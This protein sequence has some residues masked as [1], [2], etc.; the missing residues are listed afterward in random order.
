MWD[1]FWKLSCWCTYELLGSRN[2]PQGTSGFEGTM[3]IRSRTLV[4][5]Y[6][7]YMLAPHQKVALNVLKTGHAVPLAGETWEK[8]RQKVGLEARPPNAS[9]NPDAIEEIVKIA[10]ASGFDKLVEELRSS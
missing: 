8:L 1:L 3:H 4:L 6:M 10:K 5:H 7:L 2:H 9:S